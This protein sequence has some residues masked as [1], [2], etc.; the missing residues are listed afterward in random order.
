VRS[1]RIRPKQVVNE[2][3]LTLNFEPGLVERYGSLRE[4]IATGVYQRGLTNVAPSLDKAPGNLSVELSE[5]PTRKFGVESL[6]LYI[7]KF[8]DLTPIYYLVEKFLHK[9]ESEVEHDAALAQI[10]PLLE[11]LGPLLKKAGLA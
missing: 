8:N 11:Q 4:C 2:N 3:Q 6:E 7:E 10:A 9:P 5:D 1:A